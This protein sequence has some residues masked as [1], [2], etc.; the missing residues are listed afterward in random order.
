MKSFWKW[1]LKLFD[2][3]PNTMIKEILKGTTAYVNPKDFNPKD[4]ENLKDVEEIKLP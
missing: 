3:K 1:L 4:I 2:V